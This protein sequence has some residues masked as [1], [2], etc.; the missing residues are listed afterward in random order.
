MLKTYINTIPYTKFILITDS[1]E[2]RNIKLFN[3]V[4]KQHLDQNNKIQYCVFEGV[5]QNKVRD[6]S[7][8]VNVNLHNFV[9]SPTHGGQNIEALEE[10]TNTTTSADIIVIDSLANAILLHGLPSIYRILNILKNTKTIK[11][12]IAVLHQD[13]LLEEFNQSVVY[14]KNLSTLSIEFQPKFLSDLPR[15]KY[16]YKKSGGKTISE[17]EEYRFENDNLITNKVTKPDPSQLIDNST[18]KIPNPEELSTFRIGLTDEEKLSRDKVILPYLPSASEEKPEE[19][20]KIFY[21][22]DEVDDWDEE[23]PDDDL[24]I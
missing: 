8:H 22:F 23:D 2:N 17:V 11:Q 21:K 13:L 19:G 14:F 6:Y 24:D 12:V 5:F 20:G 16:Q 1:L 7:T 4:L 9:S 18:S 10:L 15:L 3:Y